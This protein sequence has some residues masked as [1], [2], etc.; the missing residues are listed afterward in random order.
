M[1]VPAHFEESRAD[2]LHQLIR[3]YALG[4]LITLGS[5][6]LEANHVPFEI[7]AASGDHGVL[8]AHVARSNPVWRDFSKD[9]DAL[10]V[11]QGAQAYISPSWYQTKQE[12][13]KVV[14]TYNYVVVHAY[15]A[16]RIIDDAKWLRD[17][18]GRLTERYEAQQLAPWKVSDAPEDYIEKMLGAIVG[19][20]IPINRLVGKWKVSQNRPEVDRHGVVAGLQQSGREEPQIMAAAVAVALSGKRS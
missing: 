13:E 3:D 4:T 8:R 6:G 7:D 19:I 9:T 1:Y 10:V 17:L 20:E 16:L 11:F 18:V 12:N 5:G 14:P 15:G 2:V